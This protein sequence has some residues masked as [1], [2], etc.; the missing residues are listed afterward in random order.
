MVSLAH[1]EEPLRPITLGQ[2]PFAKSR[3]RLAPVTVPSRSVHKEAI[4]LRLRR[5]AAFLA[6]ALLLMCGLVSQQTRAWD[7]RPVEIDA[8]LKGSY[9]NQQCA[10]GILAAGQ[11][12]ALEIE[13]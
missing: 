8:S 5:A 7:L 9:P 1:G 6:L 10:S 12:L 4:M 11:E 3:F 13:P 2:G